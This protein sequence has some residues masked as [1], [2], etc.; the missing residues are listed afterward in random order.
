MFT[1]GIYPQFSCQNFEYDLFAVKTG[2]YEDFDKIG[3]CERSFTLVNDH[4]HCV[5]Y[6]SHLVAKKERSNV[7]NVIVL[8][9]LRS[10]SPT[11]HG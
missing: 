3:L 5:K 1:P 10:A 9:C 6:R 2:R 4:S 11:R 7:I 8:T